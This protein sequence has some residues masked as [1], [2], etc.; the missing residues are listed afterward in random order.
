M[1]SGGDA[2]ANPGVNSVMKLI[3]FL[4]VALGATAALAQT[5]PTPAAA[6]P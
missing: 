4:A 3:L 5:V 6:E 2:A 1:S